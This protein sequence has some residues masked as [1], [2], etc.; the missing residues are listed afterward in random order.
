M[1]KLGNTS[2]MHCYKCCRFIS[3]R[4][5]VP[6]AIIFSV[7]FCRI[8]Y[9]T[10]LSRVDV[11][12][13]VVNGVATTPASVCHFDLLHHEFVLRGPRLERDLIRGPSTCRD[14]RRPLPDSVRT[15]GRWQIQ[16]TGSDDKLVLYSAFY[17]DR[18]AVGVVPWIRILGVAKLANRT[19]YCHVWYDAS[20]VPYV[21]TVVV[22]VTGRDIGYSVNAIN[23]V[24]Y[25]FSCRLLC[26][27]PAPSHVSVVVDRCAQSA[28]FVP[29]ERPVRAEP[30][31][32][33]GVCVAIAFGNIPT[34]WFVEW[35][36]LTWMLGVREFNV[37][38]AGMV[39]MSEVF[40]YYTRRGWLKVHQMPPPVS[41]LSKQISANNTY[42]TTTLE[43]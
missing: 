39:N 22:N 31:I 20:Y 10:L 6:F 13:V 32:E 43:V 8:F 23:Y 17:D 33:F 42:S 29:V 28:V 30:D 34:P 37:Y 16:D 25:L 24:Q 26:T 27:E 19:H 36:Q 1:N 12:T 4:T 35:M 15:N 9:T 11:D 18:P 40:D 5:A 7:S 21:T 38:D 2:L 14:V 3:V 41:D